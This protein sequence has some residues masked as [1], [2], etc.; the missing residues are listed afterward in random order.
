M[1][2]SVFL[3]LRSFVTAPKGHPLNVRQDQQQNLGKQPI[4]QGSKPK[5]LFTDANYK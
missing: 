4:H 5:G 1:S 3:F 2:R